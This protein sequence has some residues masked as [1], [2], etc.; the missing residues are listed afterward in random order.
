MKPILLVARSLMSV[1]PLQP[2]K[3]TSLLWFW[4]RAE[5]YCKRKILCTKCSWAPSFFLFFSSELKLK[6]PAKQDTVVSSNFLKD[7]TLQRKWSIYSVPRW[8]PAWAISVCNHQ[9]FWGNLPTIS[10]AKDDQWRRLCHFKEGECHQSCKSSKGQ[11]GVELVLY[12]DTC[13]LGYQALQQVSTIFK[14]II[15]I[16]HGVQLYY[17]R[18]GYIQWNGV[19]LKGVRL[20]ALC[21]TAPYI[22]VND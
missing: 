1:I 8:L 3:C 10:P 6:A 4:S 7:A 11:V 12:A 16:P 9:M 5:A 14:R 13:E 2:K 19:C 15:L 18:V 20:V 21:R 17:I 22:V